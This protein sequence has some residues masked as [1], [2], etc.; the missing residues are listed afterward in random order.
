MIWF[1]R[2]FP[3]FMV[4]WPAAF[5]VFVEPHRDADARAPVLARRLWLATLAAL[6]V[7]AGVQAWIEA[8]LPPQHWLRSGWPTA[9]AVSASMILWFGFGVPA[10]VARDPGWR[11]PRAAP[12]RSAALAPRH[13]HHPVP[14]AAWV[15]GWIVFALCAGA[16]LWAVL[17]GAHAA[18]LL[19]L[20][21]WVFMAGFGARRTVLEAEPLDR[22]GTP[23]L[24]RQYAALRAFKAWCFYALGL[25][26]T[27]CFSA[28]ALLTVAHPPLAGWAG[29][30]LGTTL[31]LFGAVFGTLAS[32]RRARAN[33]LLHERTREA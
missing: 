24:A 28:V 10:L 15:A 22:E 30:A 7:H 31:G 26:G 29:A 11:A 3:V 1:Q 33:R 13:L 9:Y 6:L 8:A 4:L 14:R 2:L 5:S 20:A 19:G 18:I 16:S 27:V 23:E 17:A 12:E 32:V 21:W 25:A